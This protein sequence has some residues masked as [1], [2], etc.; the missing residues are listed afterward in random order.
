[1]FHEM[2]STGQDQYL[3]ATGEKVKVVKIAVRGVL[4]IVH[5]DFKDGEGKIIGHGGT[6]YLRNNDF[7]VGTSDGRLFGVRGDDY[8]K[9]LSPSPVSIPVVGPK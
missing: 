3:M 4:E 5:P 9:S 1:M 8:P 7:L 6:I 2:V